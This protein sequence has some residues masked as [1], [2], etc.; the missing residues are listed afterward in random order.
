MIRAI[1]ISTVAVALLAASGCGIGDAQTKLR[2][3]VDAK[4]QELNQCYAAALERDPQT[5][6]TMSAWLHVEDQQGRIDE[7]EFTDGS[8]QDPQL[9]SCMT[10]TL[11]QVQ[12]AEAP[13]ANMK[14]EYTFE[15]HRQPAPPPQQ[16]AQAPAPQQPQA[17]AQQAPAQQPAGP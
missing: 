1:S 2:S 15:L 10:N 11:T 14:V 16:S 12:L 6:G 13:A 7:V 4:N 8:A 9:Q 3:A 5:S 17:P